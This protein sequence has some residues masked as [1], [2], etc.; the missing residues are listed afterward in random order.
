MDSKKENIKSIPEP[1]LRRLPLYCNLL[2]SIPKGDGQSISSTIIGRELG[3]DPTQV[4][5]DIAFTGIIGKPKT[6]YDVQELFDTL[7]TFLGWR[8]IRDTFLVGAGN[9]GSALMGFNPFE[10]YGVRIVAAFDID[11]GKIGTAIQGKQVLP[12]EKLPNLAERMHIKLGILTTPALIAQE[13]TDIMISGGIRG[14]WN[15]SQVVLNVPDGVIVQSENLFSSL[16][17][18]SQRLTATLSKESHKK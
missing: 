12:L 16:S 15:F 2:K 5:K 10:E 9:L 13:V 3:L 7:E 17:V 1:T 8:N 18:L 11:P 14:I 4:R 6:G